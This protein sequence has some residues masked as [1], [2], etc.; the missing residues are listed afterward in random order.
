MRRAS[1]CLK[2]AAECARLAEAEGDLELKAYL[3]KLASS[4][5]R[6]AEETIELEEAQRRPYVDDNNLTGTPNVAHL[7]IIP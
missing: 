7:A 5:T 6:A 1:E 3:S 4:W 2:H